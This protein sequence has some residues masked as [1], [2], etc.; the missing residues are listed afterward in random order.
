MHK[1]RHTF[2]S[3]AIA[4][5]WD[6]KRIQ[7]FIG[8]KDPETV[9]GVYAHFTRNQLSESSTDVHE[10]VLTPM[11]NLFCIEN[12][13]VSQKCEPNQKSDKKRENSV[14]AEFPQTLENTRFSA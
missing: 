14:A 8:D 2:T 13:G 7:A 5:G 10:T 12:E 11:S 1:L 9:M 3:H 6:L 4:A